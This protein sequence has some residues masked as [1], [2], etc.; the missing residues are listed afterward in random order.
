MMT[1]LETWPEPKPI[2]LTIEDFMHLDETG[3][4]QVYAKTELIGGTI[5]AM[6]SQLSAHARFKSRL[7]RRIADVVEVALP[8]YEAWVD[9]S[10]AIPPV[11]MPEPDVVVTRFKPTGMRMPVP[12]DTVALL[13]EIADTTARYD[14]G[15]K[16][17][18][19]ASAGVPEYWVADI[20]AGSIHQFW[21]PEP[22]GYVEHRQQSLGTRLEAVSTPLA[23]D[24][25]EA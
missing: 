23:I 12:V 21:K 8:D 3:A 10:V 11:D 22:D 18:L 1:V 25:P 15:T 4:F 14:L 24:I 2:K 6:N 13:V 5:V 20:A 17:L 19:Y 7:F 9:V 16:A